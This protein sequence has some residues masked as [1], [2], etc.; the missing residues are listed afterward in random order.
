[1]LRN[2]TTN[3]ALVPTTE[4]APGWRSLFYFGACPPVFII[5]WRALLPETN[6]FQVLKAEREE[7][8]AQK[9]EA[10]AH[11]EKRPGAFKSFLKDANAAMRANWFLFVYM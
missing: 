3:R 4:P 6:Y 5:I 2:L 11:H 9:A 1:M 10:A 8:E 7:R